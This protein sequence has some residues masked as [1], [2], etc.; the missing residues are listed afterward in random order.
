MTKTVKQ[1]KVS[2]FAGTWH[3]SEMSNFDE[4]YL[5][6]SDEPAQLIL[7]AEKDG[8]VNGHY[9]V[10]TM[11]AHLEGRL[12]TFGGETVLIF[13]AEGSNDGHA[14]NTA[15]WMRLKG[16]SVIDGEFL[17]DY[18]AFTAKRV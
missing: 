6:D 5:D 2:N 8:S 16:R 14:F 11:D 3:I 7:K 12:C 13:C 17:N 10:G 18:G 4:D 15:G 1:P 9:N